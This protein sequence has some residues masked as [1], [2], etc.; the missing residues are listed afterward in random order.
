MHCFLLILSPPAY[1]TLL[2]ALH[3]Q[4]LLLFSSLLFRSRRHSQDRYHHCR[5]TPFPKPSAQTVSRC[6]R[7]SKA[8]VSK[9]FEKS[10]LIEIY[11]I[12]HFHIHCVFAWLRGSDPRLQPR[13]SHPLKSHLLHALLFY[14]RF[15]ETSTL[16]DSIPKPNC[17]SR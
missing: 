2:A 3:A 6:H 7:T 16:N 17:I 8:T 1:I 13:P 9:D 15:I 14:L 4:I 10:K 12:L 5:F 11:V